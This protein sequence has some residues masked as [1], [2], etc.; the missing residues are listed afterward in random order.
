MDSGDENRK[1]S[2][3]EIEKKMMYGAEFMKFNEKDFSFEKL[4]PD[5]MMKYFQGERVDSTEIKFVVLFFI[6]FFIEGKNWFR[7]ILQSLS[8]KMERS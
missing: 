7:R 4:I 1:I 8:C 5:M 6:F 2:I 3:N